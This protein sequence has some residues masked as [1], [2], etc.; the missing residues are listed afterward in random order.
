MGRSLLPE[1]EEV[2][3]PETA[4]RRRSPSPS[5]RVVVRAP[6]DEGRLR[7]LRVRCVRLRDDVAESIS[8]GSW[9][10]PDGAAARH[11]HEAVVALHNARIQLELD[12]GR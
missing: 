11:A 8:G 2:L 10:P 7:D 3:Q 4:A 1:W 12:R 9:G 5:V 6:V